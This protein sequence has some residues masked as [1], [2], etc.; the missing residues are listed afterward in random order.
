MTTTG[1]RSEADVLRTLT[2]GTRTLAELYALCEQ[3]TDVSRDGGLDPV[4]GHPSDLRWKRRLRCD[5]QHLRAAGRGHR[6]DR[7]IWAIQG[8]PARP[9]RLTLVVSGATPLEFELRLAEATAL[10]AELDEPADLIFAD[11]PWGIR[12]GEDPR[13]TGGHGY[14]RDHSKV[15]GGYVDVDPDRYPAF[16]RHWVQAAAE[17][18]RPGG[19][20]AIV[21]GPQR[22]AIVQVAAEEAGLTWVTSIAAKKDFPLA[23]TRRP[24]CAHWRVTVMCRGSLR[25]PG[26]VFNPPDD[27]PAAKS[28]HLYPLD[29]WVANGRADRRGDLLRYDNALPQPLVNRTIRAFSDPG[30]HVVD[31]FTGSGTTMVGCWQT[32]RRFTGGDVNLEAVRFAGARLLAEHAWPAERHPGLFPTPAEQLAEQLGGAPA[33]L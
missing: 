25:H 23:T 4:P 22:S 16:T 33:F 11:G 14:R 8:T 29:W 9:E 2:T 27:Q 17:A 3:R 21:T 20:L 12:R 30:A 24:S 15:V 1:L 5:L 13:F 7:A 26:R 10:L 19:Q 32:G 6:V 18:L 28:G 31:P